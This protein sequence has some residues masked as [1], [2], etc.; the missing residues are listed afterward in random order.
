V[1]QGRFRLRRTH[2]QRHDLA[3]K[4]IAQLDCLEERAH[5][6]RADF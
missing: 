4:V 6:E 5:V 2:R 1:F 3:A